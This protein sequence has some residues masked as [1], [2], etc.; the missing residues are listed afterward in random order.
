MGRLATETLMMMIQ[1]ES[2]NRLKLRT[3]DRNGAFGDEAQHAHA[4]KRRGPPRHESC[5]VA[6][7]PSVRHFKR[8]VEERDHERNEKIG[9]E[10]YRKAHGD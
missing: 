2:A 8:D 9:N 10:R 6:E 7:R 4:D 3:D 5:A 1:D